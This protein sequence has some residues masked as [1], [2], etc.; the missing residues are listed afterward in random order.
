M[1]Q[2]RNLAFLI[3]SVFLLGSTRARLAEQQRRD[4]ALPSICRPACTFSGRED[5][6]NCLSECATCV[7][8]G[9]SD[10][11][12]LCKSYVFLGRITKED[13]DDCVNGSV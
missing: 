12:C 10:A 13:F 5:T 7:N 6:G 9:E 11:V 4:Q 3:L 1:F 8:S 2:L